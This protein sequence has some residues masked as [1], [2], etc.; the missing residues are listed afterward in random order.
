[1]Y[2]TRHFLTTGKTTQPG[3]N[4]CMAVRSE[5]CVSNHPSFIIYCRCAC[6]RGTVFG[7]TDIHIYQVLLPVKIPINNRPSVSV[8]LYPHFIYIHPSPF[9]KNQKHPLPMCTFVCMCPGLTWPPPTLPLRGAGF[10]LQL[11]TVAIA[12]HHNRLPERGCLPAAPAPTEAPHS[13]KKASQSHRVQNSICEHTRHDHHPH[14]PSVL[15]VPTDVSSPSPSPVITSAHCIG[16][17]DILLPHS[18]RFPDQIKER[19]PRAAVFVSMYLSTLSAMSLVAPP[20]PLPPPSAKDGE[21]DVK[22][23]R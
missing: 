12:P 5:N 19:N 13:K 6:V 3:R 16:G 20:P 21:Y 8:C 23:V 18:L 22:V 1:M 17:V 15:V 9:K 10:H 11:V 4:D 14:D 2:F 7:V